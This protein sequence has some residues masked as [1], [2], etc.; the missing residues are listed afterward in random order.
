[1][2]CLLLIPERSLAFSSHSTV[3]GFRGGENQSSEATVFSSDGDKVIAWNN[4][5]E[6][7]DSN[8]FEVRAYSRGGFPDSQSRGGGD[9]TLTSLETNSSIPEFSSLALSAPRRSGSQESVKGSGLRS[10]R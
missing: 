4:S 6:F 2:N 10:Q 9:F 7:T 8:S 5:G 3:N 1:M